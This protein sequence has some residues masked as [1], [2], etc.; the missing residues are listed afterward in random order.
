MACEEL[1]RFLLDTLKKCRV[2]ARVIDPAL[3][4]SERLDMGLRQLLQLDWDI[5]H[6][7]APD[8]FVPAEKRVYLLTDLFDCC[9]LFF[10]LPGAQKPS[11]FLMGPYLTKEP[12]H[13]EIIESCEQLG[14]PPR[15]TAQIERYYVDTVFIAAES[16]L[17]S[18]ID[19][20][21]ERL[22]PEKDFQLVTLH[23]G[24]KP[25]FVMPQRT[26][27]GMN[28][29]WNIE[30]MEKRYAY[31]NEMLQAV[32]KGQ[33]HKAKLLLPVFSTFSFERRLSDPLRDLKNYCII[34][35]T[36]L[37]KTA[38]STGVHPVFLDRISSSF[39]LRIEQ[40][41]AIPAV[42]GLMMTMFED[43]C[44]LVRNH[45][46]RDHSPPVQK[47]ITAIEADLSADLSLSALASMQNISKS[48]L[49]SLFKKETDMTITEYVNHK[50]I[51]YASV[52]LSTTQL[53]IQTIAQ[54]CGMLDV[55]YFSRLFKKIKGETPVEYRQNA[56]GRAQ[57]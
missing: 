27:G 12:T 10:L 21:C 47:A 54:H 49:S 29:D 32:A 5:L 28:A 17:F 39:A 19:S 56:A 50:R 46:L 9:Y 11:L 1:L 34:M 41:E 42:H 25:P 40:L 35:N 44:R 18:M 37:R 3:L 7:C 38:E 8:D 16:Y 45:S 13:E 36:L 57:N 51:Q 22:W 52:L 15:M 43:Y 31:E 48:Y 23:P 14:V 26:D 24:E 30:L 33:T 2:P 6:L 4:R 20:F 53:Q 55:H